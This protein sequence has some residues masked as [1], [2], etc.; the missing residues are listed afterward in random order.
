MCRDE[1]AVAADPIV[2]EAAIAASVTSAAEA[3]RIRGTPSS[4]RMMPPIWG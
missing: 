2:T 3:A 1:P 4:P